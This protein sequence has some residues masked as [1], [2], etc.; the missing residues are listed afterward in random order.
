[1]HQHPERLRLRPR[2]VPRRTSLAPWCGQVA[3]Q[4]VPV[5]LARAA[6]SP[7]TR[8]RSAISTVW[9]AQARRAASS[10]RPTRC[11][12]Q[13][14]RRALGPRPGAGRRRRGRPRPGPGTRP[15]RG[16]GSAAEQVDVP[17]PWL[18][19]RAPPRA[20]CPPAAPAD[21]A[22]PAR[23]PSA[24]PAA[25]AGSPRRGTRSWVGPGRRPE[26]RLV[27]VH[28]RMQVP[29]VVD[30]ARDQHVQGVPLVAGPRRPRS[31]GSSR[32][33]CSSRRASGVIHSC[34]TNVHAPYSAPR[35]RAGFI[36]ANGEARR[37]ISA[38]ASSL[39]GDRD[40]LQHVVGP[41]HLDLAG[42]EPRA[43][44]R[45]SS[46]ISRS[47]VACFVAAPARPRARATAIGGVDVCSDHGVTG[48]HP[49]RPRV[50][51]SSQ[52]HRLSAWRPAASP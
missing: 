14:G 35:L 29:A 25:P 27:E 46:A 44:P 51:R 10:T 11:G 2:R 19:R 34:A 37:S 20:R 39:P 49:D 40:E 43:Q 41:Q 4:L 38:S 32:T 3:G 33:R 1:M 30:D 8:P 15:R 22:P 23:S 42:P 7:Q 36:A 48:W 52:P 5:A 50:V 45:A 9:A 6:S 12:G 16:R 28:Q 21:R 47:A 26:T 31:P 13:V 17:E 24:P 18:R